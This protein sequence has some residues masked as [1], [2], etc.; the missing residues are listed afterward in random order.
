MVAAAPREFLLR[1]QVLQS[2]SVSEEQ[3]EV[4]RQDAVLDV[5]EHLQHDVTGVLNGCV[6]IV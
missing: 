6:V 2:L 4:G 5:A 3:R 1:S